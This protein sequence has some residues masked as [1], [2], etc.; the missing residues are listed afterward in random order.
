MW[1]N[2]RESV[3]LTTDSDPLWAGVR[4]DPL[5]VTYD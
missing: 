2:M 1:Y 3:R 5:V 4:G